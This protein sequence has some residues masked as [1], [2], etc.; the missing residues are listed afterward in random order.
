MDVAKSKK[1][2]K[3]KFGS[4]EQHKNQQLLHNMGRRSASPALHQ[5]NLT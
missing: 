3:G 2:K 1:K 4:R 5:N